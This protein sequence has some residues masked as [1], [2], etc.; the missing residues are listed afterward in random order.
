MRSNTSLDSSRDFTQGCGG[1]FKNWLC[2][3]PLIRMSK[4]GEFSSQPNKAFLRISIGLAWEL[5]GEI[6]W[7]GRMIRRKLDLVWT[8]MV[9][10]DD[11][12]WFLKACLCSSHFPFL[13]IFE[14]FSWIF[15]GEVLGCFFERFFLD[16]TYE[17]LCLFAWWSCSN[18][19]SETTSIWWF[20]V[21]SL[22]RC[23]WE[24]TF[25]SSWLSGFWGPS[26][27]PKVAHEVP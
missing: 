15:R 2:L 4:G 3:I 22:G 26:F 27:E 25:D 12:A 19:P 9:C 7:E 18:K 10:I 1:S 17:D 24:L 11:S 23:S 16:V 6:L 8:F 5:H 20:S 21:E 14:A 13:M